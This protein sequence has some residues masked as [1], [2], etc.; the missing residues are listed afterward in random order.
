MNG[1]GGVG[2]PEGG[3]APCPPGWLVYHYFALASIQRGGRTDGSIPITQTGTLRHR[4]EKTCSQ[5]HSKSVTEQ[6][7]ELGSQTVGVARVL[8]SH[9]EAEQEKV[10]VS[11]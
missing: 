4:E 2:A 6:V 7:A 10:K 5:S 3:P 1:D 8:V 9:G 11:Q